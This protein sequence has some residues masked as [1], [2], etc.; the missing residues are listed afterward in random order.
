MWVVGNTPSLR[1]LDIGEQTLCLY[2][3]REKPKLLFMVAQASYNLAF[4][5]HFSPISFH[6]PHN[7]YT[8]IILNFP[9]P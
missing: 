7:T 8:P 3:G 5:Q 9:D 2:F 6:S 4:L 1:M